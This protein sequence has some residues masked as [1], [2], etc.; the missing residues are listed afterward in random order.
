MA[1]VDLETVSVIL[2]ILDP[3]VNFVQTRINMDLNAITV[4]TVFVT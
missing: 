2:D 3:A 1:L 4:S